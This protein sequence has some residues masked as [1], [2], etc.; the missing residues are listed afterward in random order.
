[1]YGGGRTF[2]QTGCLVT[3]VAMLTGDEPPDCAQKLTD[4]GVMEGAY[5]SRPELVTD[6][7]PDLSYGG[8]VNWRN[9]PADL[10][11][12]GQW[13][14]TGPVVIETEFAP[15]GATP[16]ED[17][18]F[19]VA[20]ELDG[21]DL[22]IAD[23]WTGERVR[24]LE[25]YALSNWDLARAIY[26]VRLFGHEAAEPPPPPPPPLSRNLLGVHQ[27]KEAGG[28]LE[29]YAAA[30]P[31][32]YKTVLNF[33]FIQAIKE[34]SPETITIIRPFP[35]D[36]RGKSAVESILR[37][38]K[39]D[40][41]VLHPYIDYVELINEQVPSNNQ[42]AIKLAVD[43]EIWGMEYL[44]ALGYPV[45]PLILNV[46]VGNPWGPWDPFNEQELLVPA[47]EAS[48][49]M[50]GEAC[51]GYHGYWPSN[52]SGCWLRFGDVNGVRK[53]VGK[54][55]AFRAQEWDRHTFAPRGLKPLYI[56][57]EMGPIGTHGPRPEDGY[58]DLM[59]HSG[60]HSKSCLGGSRSRLI[61]ELALWQAE[62][63]EWNATHEN[64]FR[65]GTVFTTPGVDPWDSFDFG[66]REMEAW[67][68]RLG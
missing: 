6:A 45:K 15:G 1:M 49:A 3:C 9:T 13:L 25:R 7:Y 24:L 41:A 42:D 20:L 53:D 33:Q 18:H 31:S 61:D 55:Y 67:T 12:L 63:A 47:V 39:D 27:Q 66:E 2:G 10:G 32:V 5:L 68:E 46:A 30:H 23:P 64:R 16:P 60:W 37:G 58:I 36:I 54:Y 19:V 28:V 57:T 50:F 59:S 38:I 17:Q 14:E 40:L 4:A 22:I 48:I 11:R 43:T 29:Y 34:V 56:A 52:L 65:G 51:I 21:G 26:G 62:W 44:K 8:T 35:N